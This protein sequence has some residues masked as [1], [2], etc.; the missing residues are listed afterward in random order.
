MQECNKRDRV[1]K[2][3]FFPSSAGNCRINGSGK[4]KCNFPDP[5]PFVARTAEPLDP[6]T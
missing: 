1:W 6:G 5:V 3:A 2:I 4:A